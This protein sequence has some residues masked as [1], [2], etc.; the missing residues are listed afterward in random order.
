MPSESQTDF[1]Y[2][3]PRQV[4]ELLQVREITVRNWLRTGVL[5][6]VKIG[7]L[8]RV[9]RTALSVLDVRIAG[10]TPPGME[11]LPGA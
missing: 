7:H 8:W 3:T 9:P 6:G 10:K 1:G 5:A 2:Y 11:T 4:A